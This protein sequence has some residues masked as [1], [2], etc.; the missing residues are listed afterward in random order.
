[1]SHLSQEESTRR[2]SDYAERYDRRTD[3]WRDW[4]DELGKVIANGQPTA[5]I[6][7]GECDYHHLTNRAVTCL[8]K[9]LVDDPST[10]LEDLNRSML[11]AVRDC[12][13]TTAYQIMSWVE[14][15]TGEPK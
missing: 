8:R 14:E 6:P 13:V 1:M 10:C 9:V 3:R 5:Q 15:L 12:G 11:L 2:V 4:G 7:L